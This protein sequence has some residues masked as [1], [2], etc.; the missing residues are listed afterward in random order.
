MMQNSVRTQAVHFCVRFSA[1]TYARFFRA[2]QP[3]PPVH[4]LA[5]YSEPF[6]KDEK[7][8]DDVTKN[9]QALTRK[10]H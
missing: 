4:R 10:R 6:A 9:L 7:T 2:Q 1:L 5:A 3:R 8:L